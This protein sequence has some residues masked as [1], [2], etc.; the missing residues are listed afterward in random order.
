MDGIFA[1]YFL[2]TLQ[3]LTKVNANQNL[4]VCR[5]HVDTIVLSI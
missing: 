1:F 4:K 3:K 5:N 2:S